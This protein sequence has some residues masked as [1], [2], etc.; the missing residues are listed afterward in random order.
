M[1]NI[2]FIIVLFLRGTGFY[3][4]SDG[5]PQ[6]SVKT[7]SVSVTQSGGSAGTKSVLLNKDP[8]MLLNEHC[9]RNQ[10]KVGTKFVLVCA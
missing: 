5:C 2:H 9:Q 1:L 7:S 4:T 8:I 6:W 10:L 3:N